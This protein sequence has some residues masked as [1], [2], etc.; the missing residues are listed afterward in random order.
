MAYSPSCSVSK[1]L[2]GGSIAGGVALTLPSLSEGAL[3]SHTRVLY[4]TLPLPGFLYY[5]DMRKMGR[6]NYQKNTSK[7]CMYVYSLKGMHTYIHTYINITHTHILLELT[8][9]FNFPGEK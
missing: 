4:K 3:S 2:A 5:Q 6:R 1:S 7:Y 8:V 9:A